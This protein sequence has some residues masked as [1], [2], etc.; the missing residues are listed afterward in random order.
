MHII[1]KFS[2]ES[3]VKRNILYTA[4]SENL[5]KLENFLRE[6]RS[7]KSRAKKKYLKNRGK[8]LGNIRL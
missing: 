2:I 4:N 6:I 7:I 8:K 1:E 3:E 5:R